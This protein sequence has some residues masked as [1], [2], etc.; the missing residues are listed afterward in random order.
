MFGIAFFALL[1]RCQE[2]GLTGKRFFGERFQST[3]HKT[4]GSAP[5]TRRLRKQALAKTQFAALRLQASSGT[6]QV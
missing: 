3:S 2:L 5:L 1:L 4:F 6:E